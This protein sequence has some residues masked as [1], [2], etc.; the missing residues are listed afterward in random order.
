MRMIAIGT[1]HGRK[2][3][4]ER[5]PLDPKD[6]GVYAETVVK[7]GLEF[8]T[9]EFGVSEAEVTALIASGAAKRKTREEPDDT[10]GKEP[11][12]PPA[13]AHARPAGAQKPA[14]GAQRPGT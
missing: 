5:N 1:I 12:K 13:A 10:V 4:R 11:A 7:P 2:T 6:R 3:I 14:Q 8:D 9:E